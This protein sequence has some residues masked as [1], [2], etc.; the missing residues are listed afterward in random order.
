MRVLI[1]GTGALGCV[2]AARLAA[3]ADVTMLG[4]W[5]EGVA[6]VRASGIRVTEP[7]GATWTARVHAEDDP[8]AVSAADV[9]LVLVKSYQTVRAAAWAARCLRPDG[10]AVTLQNGL[11]NLPALVAAVGEPRSAVGVTYNAATMLGPGT[12]RHVV[13]LPTHLSLADPQPTPAAQAALADLAALLNAAGLEAHVSGDVEGRL[14][15]KAVANAAI[16]PLTALW[17]VTNGEPLARPE[18]RSLLAALACEATAVARA[19]GAVL[20]FADPVAYVESVCRATAA[21]RSSMLQDVERGRPTEIDSISGI[22]VSEGHR[23]GVPVPLTEAVWQ[24]VRA[25]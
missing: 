24:L 18:R 15:G 8:A 13:S 3:H 19:R 1:L 7:D 10:L 25:L 9:A 2:F 14:W 16:N 12:V 5:A 20:P 6:A 22:I 23:L 4:A 11:D 17:R 21:N